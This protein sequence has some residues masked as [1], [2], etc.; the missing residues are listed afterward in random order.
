MFQV[1][2]ST[3]NS[4]TTCRGPIQTTQNCHTKMSLTHRPLKTPTLFLA[5]LL[6]QKFHPWNAPDLFGEN[7]N[8]NKSALPLVVQVQGINQVV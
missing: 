1:S 2:N 7:N 8:E 4:K 3:P 6:V 5:M